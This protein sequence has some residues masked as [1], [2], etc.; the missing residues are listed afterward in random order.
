MLLFPPR[1]RASVAGPELVVAPATFARVHTSLIA[2]VLVV[3]LGTFA[4]VYT[5]LAA[6]VLV[7]QET[8]ALA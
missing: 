4:R 8:V 2:V 1:G 6:V 3:D 5:S 7:D